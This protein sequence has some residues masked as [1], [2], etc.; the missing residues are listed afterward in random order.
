MM[1]WMVIG[2]FCACLLACVIMDVSV[3]HALVLGLLLFLAYGRTKGLAWRELARL[4]FK[5]VARVRTILIAFFLIGI[6]TAFWRASGTIA[7][8]VCYAADLVAPPAFLLMCFLLN[9]CISILTGTSFGTAATMGVICAAMGNSLGV[10]PALTGGAVLSGVYLGDRCSPVSTSAL[11]VAALTRTDIYQNIKGM[12]RSS[13]LPFLLA[14]AAYFAIG[15]LASPGA[16]AI[17]DLE[18][19][20]S[21]GFEM[22][23]ISLLPAAVIILLSACR[24]DVKLSMAASIMSAVPLC[25]FLQHMPAGSLFRAALMGFCP[26]DAELAAMVGGG[27]IVSMCKVAGIVCL[28][29]GY[30]DLFQK[31]GLLN[32]ARQKMASL[33]RAATPFAAML[34]A[35]VIT[36][37]IACNQTL[38]IL[39]TNQLCT[40]MNRDRDAFAID[41]EDSAVV[42]APLIPWSIAGAVPL[43]AVDAPMTGILFAFYLFFLPAWRL[44]VSWKRP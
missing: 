38:T 39:L 6:L 22:H 2:L 4:T 36:G 40:G 24:V 32:G 9:G 1:E 29:S 21:R 23:W 37:M 3:L 20:F 15:I 27:G 8:I 18:Q 33:G 7:V 34:A 25:L 31:T 35:S 41:L 13:L 26:E 44:A 12:V 16:A 30:V 10:S 11:L 17:V 19:V 28:S 42:M 14:C 43:S 5:G